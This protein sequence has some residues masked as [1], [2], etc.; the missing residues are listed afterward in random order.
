MPLTD[1]APKDLRFVFASCA[2]STRGPLSTTQRTAIIVALHDPEWVPSAAEIPNTWAV[3]EA[4][5]AGANTEVPRLE[6]VS[7][8][9]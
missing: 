5:H 4:W 8:D 6:G 2:A 1:H 7:H 3:V 9:Q